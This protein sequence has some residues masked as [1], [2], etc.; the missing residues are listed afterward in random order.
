MYI[1][2]QASILPAMQQ[3]GRDR[4]SLLQKAHTGN[5]RA[6]LAQTQAQLLLVSLQ[7][8]LPILLQ[9]RNKENQQLVQ[10]LLAKVAPRLAWCADLANQKTCSLAATPC[11]AAGARCALQYRGWKQQDIQHGRAK[12]LQKTCTL[13]LA[14][15]GVQYT[16][17][18]ERTNNMGPL[19]NCPVSHALTQPGGCSSTTNTLSHVVKPPQNIQGR[20]FKPDCMQVAD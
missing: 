19:A 8:V 3:C 11:T 2:A 5:L 17:K 20:V 12:G 1:G 13:R 14:A 15:Y 10:L 7:G 6:P 16:R 18:C 9:E 4:Q